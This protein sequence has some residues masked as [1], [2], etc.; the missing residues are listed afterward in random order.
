MAI[1]I[2]R[3]RCPTYLP[4]IIQETIYTT[5]RQPNSAKFYDNSK[6]K[7][8]KHCLCIRLTGMNGLPNWLDKPRCLTIQYFGF[9]K[10]RVINLKATSYDRERY[11]KERERELRVMTELF[12]KK[13]GS[14]GGQ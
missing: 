7:V 5:R 8:G 3:D 14:H 11:R 1:K 6:G 12:C 4:E 2:K 10:T 9:G 13:S